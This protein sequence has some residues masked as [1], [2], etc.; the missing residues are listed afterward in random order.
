MP[1][2]GTHRNMAAPVSQWPECA[3]SARHE[4]AKA[5]VKIRLENSVAGHA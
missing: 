3:D 4:G 5:N 2:I 1:G